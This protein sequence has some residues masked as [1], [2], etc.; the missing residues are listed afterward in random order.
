MVYLNKC[1]FF[2]SIFTSPSLFQQ[3]TS[4]SSGGESSCEEGRMRRPTHLRPFHSRSSADSDLPLLHL[5]SDPD[6]YS[7]SE[8]SCDT[9]IYV[10]PNGGAISDRELTDNE[11]P[12]E[13]V[14]IIP[15]LLK[16]KAESG[17]VP[18]MPPLQQQQTVL[19]KPQAQLVPPQTHTQPTTLPTEPLN[20]LN[21]PPL[22]LLQ[23]P[24]P[25]LQPLGHPLP[26]VPEEGAECLKC[27]TF[28]ELQERLECID[29]SEEVA[30][31]PFEE[32][33]AN[34]GAKPDTLVPP[35][36]ETGRKG[37]VVEEVEPLRRM[38]NDQQLQEIREVVEEAELAQTMIE[39][40]SLTGSCSVTGSSGAGHTN[41]NPLQRA[42]SASLHDR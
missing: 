6:N 4:S 14:P 1:L 2:S 42:K 15:V 33:P 36:S 9:V 40:L 26:P 41:T 3:Y 39:S 16:S 35:G 23:P 11:G 30:K 7:S 12:P 10:G 29:G 28:A 8:Q 24:L 17:V 31:F 19:P 22:P 21:Q 38:S 37:G 5:S 34:R 13:F 25:L 18:T 32:V 27:N 20:A